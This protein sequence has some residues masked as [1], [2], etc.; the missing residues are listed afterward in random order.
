MPR[1]TYNDVCFEVPEGWVDASIV[2]F[3]APQPSLPTLMRS[4]QPTAERP[5][6]VMT[7][8]SASGLLFSLD[9]YARSQE[10]ILAE[11]MSELQVLERDTILIGEEGARIPVA[12][13]EYAFRGPEGNML[14]QA[15]AY[16][17]VGD[18][19]YALTATGSY[20]ASF[21]AVRQQF[22]HLV[23]SFRQSSP[24]APSPRG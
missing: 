23:E 4:K 12:L 5:S 24:A 8:A 19:M 13:R 22:L 9:D 11:I 3:V 10:R 21:A 6:V 14:R 15:H 16:L 1:V 7:R 20:D 17:R 18:V 2:S